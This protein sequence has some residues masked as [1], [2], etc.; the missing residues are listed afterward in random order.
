VVGD[1]IRSE[2]VQLAELLQSHAGWH[3]TFALVELRVFGLPEGVFLAC[4][5]I[6]A[7]TEMIHRAVVMVDDQRAVVLPPD[8]GSATGPVSPETISSE[9]FFEAMAR[10]NPILPEKLRAFLDRI[11]EAGVRPEFRKSLNLKWATS[12]GRE[13][14]LGFIT[15]QGTVWTD[16]SVGSL[17]E[18]R[19]L[20]HDYVE[21]AARTMGLEVNRTSQGEIWTLRDHRGHAP[22]IGDITDKLD[23]W[24]TAIERLLDN[25][26]NLPTQNGE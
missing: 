19:P 26:R 18:A 22:K 7:K 21:Q 8:R 5:R 14:N 16:Q 13:V 9:Q 23:N 11:S 3:F 2:A 10:I 25:L 4:P 1:G 17:L 20:A 15:Q 24:A 12:Q 6:L